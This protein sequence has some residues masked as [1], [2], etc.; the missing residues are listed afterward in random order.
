[1]STEIFRKYIDIINESQQPQ[2]LD[3]GLLSGL[4]GIIS[5]IKAIPGIQ[6]YIQ[7]A[8]SKK[9]QLIQALQHS[10]SGQDLVKNIQQSVGGQQAVAEGWGEKIGG[11][12]MASAG[13]SLL[14]GGADLLMKAYIQMGKPDL[15]Q[16][17]GQDQGGMMF[18]SSL[19]LLGALALFAGGKM[20]KQGLTKNT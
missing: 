16:L 19:V 3:E 13:G 11:A 9:E 10:S 15:T 20:F 17:S 18:L 4:Q 6:K 12:V 2:Q 14:A 5:K 1:M 7:A 8:Q